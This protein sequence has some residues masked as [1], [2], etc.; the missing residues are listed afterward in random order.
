M[1][2][3]FHSTTSDDSVAN[4]VGARTSIG[5]AGAAGSMCTVTHEHLTLCAGVLRGS[6]FSNH[7]H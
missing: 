6:T 3:S 2:G 5:S 7:G 1:G 4:F